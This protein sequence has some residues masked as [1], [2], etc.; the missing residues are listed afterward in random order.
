MRSALREHKTRE[1]ASAIATL[2][3][4]IAIVRA[5]A[6]ND[7]ILGNRDRLALPDEVLLLKTGSD[8]EKALL[9]YA[10]LHHGRTDIRTP[11]FILTDHD[12]YVRA[13]EDLVS[14]RSL[15]KCGE[16]VGEIIFHHA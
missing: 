8:R 16:I 13:G 12:S 6:G 4:A 7:P 9:L 5:V 15:D 3:D 1:T 14:L 11:E 10:L 2:D